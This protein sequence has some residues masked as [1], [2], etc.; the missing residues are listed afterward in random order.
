ML[1][2]LTWVIFRLTGVIFGLNNNFKYSHKKS[3]IDL[4]F[5]NKKSAIDLHFTLGLWSVFYPQSAFYPDFQSVF[6]L[7]L[8]FTLCL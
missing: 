3:A 8:Q 5:S 7:N 1:L 2:R 4:H 6:S